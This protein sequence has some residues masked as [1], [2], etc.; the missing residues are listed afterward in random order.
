MRKFFK[1]ISFFIKEDKLFL[2]A[3]V[4]FWIALFMV[5]F[6]AGIQTLDP[7]FSWHLRVGKDIATTNQVPLVEEYLFPTFGE[8]WVDHEWLSNLLLFLVYSF[9]GK[10][11][12]WSLGLIFAI[13][14]VG[15]IYLV[16][17]INRKY[18]VTKLARW[19]YFF[20]NTI[21]IVLGSI[22]LLRS[23]GIRLQVI[24][25]LFFVLCFWLYFKIKKEAKLKYLWGFPLLFCLWSNL[26]GT[27]VLGLAISLLLL[28][29]LFWE[30]KEKSVRLKIIIATFLTI[31]S[32][33]ITPYG[34]EL[35]KL[36]AGEYTQNT[37]Y[38]TRI[39]E[40]LPLYA[41]PYIEWYSTFYLSL[42]IFL[43]LASF[44]LKTLPKK[45]NVGLYFI[46]VI[47]LLLLSIKSRRFISMFILCSFPF[48]IFIISYIFKRIFTKKIAINFFGITISL[49]AIIFI[50]NKLSFTST[51]PLDLLT[52]NSPMGPYKAV[53]FLKENKHLHKHNIY[54]KYGWGGYLVWM[55]PDKLHFIDGRMPQKPLVDGTSF[56]EEYHLFREDPS[57]TKEK[58]AQ[59]DIKIALLSQENSVADSLPTH[60]KFILKY[61]FSVNIDDFDRTDALK[62]YLAE[63]WI[64]A[65]SDEF[66]II[67]LSPEIK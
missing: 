50:Y 51:I 64:K 33:L 28:M 16:S 12:Y 30:K 25:W 21:F 20:L 35:W 31:I 8:R 22:A 41:A 66:S 32:T 58:L 14:G 9:F 56:I 47:F 1:K 15:T 40:W 5:F 23:Y 42:I 7:D 49:I 11:G 43:F 60:Q 37:S 55:W 17:N 34:I 18:F 29:L 45:I 4:L 62:E 27:F 26:H 10:F 19:D 48:A 65:Y 53:E 46:F 39:F 61:F 57:L 13:I 2:V 3:N 38:L 44:I 36:I 59:Y 24:T 52:Q 67:Y 54:N 6:V 63:N